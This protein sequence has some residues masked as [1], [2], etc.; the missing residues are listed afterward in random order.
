MNKMEQHAEFYGKLF[1]AYEKLNEEGDLI[2]NISIW[3]ICDDP[4][5]S[6]SDYSYKQNG[7]YCGLFNRGC[8]RKDAYY[9]A[10]KALRD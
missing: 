10:L 7:P 4:M 3:G 1:E 2:Q 6:K 8:K 5:M 9:E